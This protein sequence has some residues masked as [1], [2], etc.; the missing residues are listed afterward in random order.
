M[1]NM[2]NAFGKITFESTSLEYL[3]VFVHYFHK[4]KSEEYY[5]I[6]LDSIDENNFGRDQVLAKKQYGNDFEYDR[7]RIERYSE[8]T[9]LNDSTIY[10]FTDWFKGLA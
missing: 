7:N 3:T 9:V 8:K 10:S 5:D 1:A 4:I 6:S 2:S